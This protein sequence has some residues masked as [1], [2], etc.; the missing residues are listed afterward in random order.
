MQPWKFYTL[1]LTLTLA[2]YGWVGLC[3]FSN[4]MDKISGSVHPCIIK[5]VTGIPC[6]SCGTTRS[7]LLILQGKFYD[8]LQFN[9]LGFVA[10]FVLMTLPFLFFYD[11]F[12]QRNLLFRLFTQSEKVI[13]NRKSAALLIL[14]FLIL[15]GRNIHKGL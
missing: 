11:A 9:P 1:M 4:G 8:A 15:W 12:K 6:P 3:F 5:T 14:F 7:V 2:A 10:V 13:C